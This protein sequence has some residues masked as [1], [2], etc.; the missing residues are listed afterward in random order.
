MLTNCF[1]LLLGVKICEIVFANMILSV[2][3]PHVRS[4]QIETLNMEYNPQKNVPLLISGI[5][6]N[7]T[8]L[9]YQQQVKVVCKYHWSIGSVTQF[10]TDSVTVLP[11]LSSIHAHLPLLLLVTCHHWCFPFFFFSFLA[12]SSIQATFP[13]KC[14]PEEIHNCCVT[15]RTIYPFYMAKEYTTHIVFMDNRAE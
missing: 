1:I 5:S 14:V 7:L 2:E 12:F 4:V 8:P 6:T 3:M 10:P 15:R 9:K 11:I 13:Y